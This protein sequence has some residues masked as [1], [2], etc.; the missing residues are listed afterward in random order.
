MCIFLV[1]AA[2]SLFSGA[3]NPC[4][5]K[6]KIQFVT[7]SADADLRVRVVTP[8][9]DALPD[10]RVQKVPWITDQAGQ[11]KIVTHSPDFRIMLVSSGED[12]TVQ[13]VDYLPGCR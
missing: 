1:T 13:Y 8:A 4:Q 11:W 3:T 5:V 2:L 7:S 10:L 12:F 6:G 9:T